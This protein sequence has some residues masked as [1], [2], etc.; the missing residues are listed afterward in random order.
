MLHNEVGIFARAY[1]PVNEM[2]ELFGGLRLMGISFMNNLFEYNQKTYEFSR[3]GIGCEF[4]LGVVCNISSSS[5]LGFRVGVSPLSS[6]FEKDIEL[7]FA[8]PTNS[9]VI[10][11]N[12][13]IS[14]SYGIKF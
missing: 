9:R 2:F 6:N 10:F 4:E 11:N 5:Y 14:I 3:M 8:Y 13:N 12:Y 1:K 7:P